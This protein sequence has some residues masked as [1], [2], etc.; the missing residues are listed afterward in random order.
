MFDFFEVDIMLRKK[1]SVSPLARE[2]VAR[3]G[4]WVEWPSIANQRLAFADN[5]PLKALEN[6]AVTAFSEANELRRRPSPRTFMQFTCI[7]FI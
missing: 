4:G 1:A 2:A 7:N 5:S 3:S 6:R